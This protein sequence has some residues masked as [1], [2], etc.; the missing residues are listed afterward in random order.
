MEENLF[1]EE[2]QKLVLQAQDSA[3]YDPNATLKNPTGYTPV[4]QG[5]D[6]TLVETTGPNDIGNVSA[7]TPIPT[8]QVEDFPLKTYGNNND[9]VS[10]SS[11]DKNLENITQSN[12][13]T[14]TLSNN[15][16]TL[17]NVIGDF[18]DDQTEDGEI[19]EPEVPVEPEPEPEVPVE[20][21]PEPEVPV[22]PEPEV[23]VEPEPEPEVPVE[24]EPEPEVPV[25]PEPEPEVPVEPEPEPEVPVEP[26]PEPEVPVEPE[27][28]PEVPVEP[29]PEPEV[30]VEPEPE[31]PS[32]TNPGNKF[33]VGNSP[34]DGITGNSGNNGDR[35]PNAGPMEGGEDD[36]GEQPGF[37][38]DGPSNANGNQTNDNETD[39]GNGR[40]SGQNSQGNNGWGNGDDDAPGRSGPNNNAE[41][42][43]TPSGNYDVLV[44]RFLDENSTDNTFDTLDLD[45][46]FDTFDFNNDL[47]YESDIASD[48]ENF[49]FLTIELSE[50]S[51][52]GFDN[53]D[54]YGD[55]A[56]G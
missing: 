24:P 56:A 44:G 6:N 20:P 15:D 40:G 27:P 31:A 41:N 30:P 49:E 21:E 18:V 10:I 26:E 43:E 28:E 48:N 12:V 19:I 36:I 14:N 22:E 34:F 32:G 50:I 33:D 7:T 47:G 45:L 37:K 17:N 52:S 2:V 3:E 1:L 46:Q 51:D 9:D 16:I 23:P 42:D 39:S 11:N 25:E 54:Y 53:F 13:R 35:T 5:E 38:G 29:E 4:G 55:D 8:K